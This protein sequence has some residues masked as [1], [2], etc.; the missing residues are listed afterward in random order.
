M[1]HEKQAMP[2]NPEALFQQLYRTHSRQIYSYL[3]GRTESKETAAD[4][5]QDVFMKIWNRKDVVE[6]IPEDQQLY[7]IFS[8]AANRVKDYYRKSQ[9]YKQAVSKMQLHTFPSPNG[10]LSQLL[11]GRE[12]FHELESAIRELPEELRSILLMKAVGGMKS[13]E[14]GAALGLPAGT[15]RYKILLARRQL[16]ETLGMLHKEKAA[17]RK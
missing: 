7:W 2:M 4:L 14:I 16:A 9:S 13:G 17:E 8:I 12:Q 15:V 10:D 3:L 6:R 1:M 11:A 5:L